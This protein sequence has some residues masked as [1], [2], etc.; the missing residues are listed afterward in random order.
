MAA[1]DARRGPR[2]RPIA[3]LQAGLFYVA[4][5][6][7]GIVP[8]AVL[9]RSPLAWLTY[10]VLLA[11]VFFPAASSRQD[12]SGEEPSARELTL[13]MLGR[14]SF[15]AIMAGLGISNFYL[16][17]VIHWLLSTIPWLSDSWSS[18][19]H[20]PWVVYGSAASTA[21][22][23]GVVAMVDVGDTLNALYP[24]RPGQRSPFFAPSLKATAGR[25]LA[26]RMLVTVSV[27]VLL[28]IDLATDMAR[29]GSDVL[30]IVCD[31]ALIGTG[32]DYLN[33]KTLDSEQRAPELA[34]NAVRRLLEAAGYQVIPRPLTGNEEA[35]TVISI[36]DFLAIRP[37]G[38]LAGRVRTIA[39]NKASDA[40]SEVSSLEPAVWVLQDQLEKKDHTRIRLTPV[41]I[42]MGGDATGSGDEAT[43]TAR[44]IIHTPAES[45]LA[46]MTDEAEWIRM[47]ERLFPASPAT[48]STA[49]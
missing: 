9:L 31:L 24:S 6:G 33:T 1:T 21:L 39:M 17:S 7:L 29:P 14:C 4:A 25:E 28:A 32:A 18:A 41:L 30:V 45:E 37:D 48:A 8:Y 49:A 44:K 46:G 42:V 20:S 43:E 26:I 36:L 15:G 11:A 38:G 12:Y 22:L 3:K 13:A 5:F 23:A 35:D 27:V 2:T 19:S 34:V 16:L 47:A 10:L 40:R